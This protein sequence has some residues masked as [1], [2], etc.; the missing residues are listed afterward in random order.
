M[1]GCSKNKM[2]GYSRSV[3]APRTS[4]VQATSLPKKPVENIQSQNVQAQSKGETSNASLN[5][6]RRSIERKRREAILKKLG[7]L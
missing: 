6:D 2:R 7:R 1:C 5:S 3:S 4:S